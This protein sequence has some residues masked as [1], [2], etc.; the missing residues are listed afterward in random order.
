MS[1]RLAAMRQNPRADWTMADVEAVCREHGVRCEPSR[2]GSSHF[3]VFH[4]A[5]AAKLTIP[6]RRP[7]KPV[8]IRKLV[9]LID[10][11][12]GT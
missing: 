11:L 5:L 6:F 3:K 12:E 2:G 4:P 8:Y 9:E 10:A 1:K 7:V